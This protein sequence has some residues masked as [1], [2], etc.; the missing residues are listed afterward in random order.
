MNPIKTLT[1]IT[2]LLPR[3]T[4]WCSERKALALAISVYANR[5]LVGVEIGVWAGRS[6]FPVAMAMRDLGKGIIHAVDPWSPNAS[7]EGYDKANADWWG[8]KANHDVAYKQF[9]SAVVST[10]TTAHIEV[11][12]CKSDAFD[13]P[14][15]I[16]YLHVDGQHTEQAIKDVKRFAAKVRIGGLVFMDDIHWFL[17]G[18]QKR[19]EVLK[20]VDELTEIGFKMLYTL[21]GGT[22]DGAMFQRIK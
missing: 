2:E 5:P 8:S 19:F 16:D 3:L 15:E 11:H 7:V 13:P 20:A 18:E 1:E 21:E 22:D 9:L 4:G 17:D 14:N 12:R 10:G 6:L